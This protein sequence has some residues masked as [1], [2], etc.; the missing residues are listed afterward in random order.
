MPFVYMLFRRIL[1]LLGFYQLTRLAFYFLNYSYFPALGFS[2]WI[3]LLSGSLRFDLSAIMYSNVLYIALFLLPF[4]HR[5]HRSVQ[6]VAKWLFVAV[7][8][9]MLLANLLDSVYYPFTLRRTNASFFREFE[10]DAHLISSLGDF[11]GSHP[12]LILAVPLV[13]FGLWKTYPLIPMPEH[14]RSWASHIMVFPVG[15]LWLGF[16][17]GSFIPSDRPIN[18]SLAADYAPDARSMSL[19]LNTPI[20]VMTTWGNIKVP[21]VNYFPDLAAA[22]NVFDPVQIYPADTLR[23]KNVVIIIVESLSKEFIGALNPGKPSYTPFLDAFIPQALVYP[24][25]FANGRRSIEALPSVVASI[26]SLSEAYVLTPY[27]T[28]RI[29]SLASVL[30]ENGWHTSF[31]HGGHD[32]SMGFSAFMRLAGMQHAYSKTDY[33]NDADYDGT[34]GIY[35]EPYLQY[36]AT[37]LNKHP[38][39]FFSALFTVSSHHP[40]R[41][42]E[43]LEDSIPAGNIPIHRSIRYTDRALQRFF[44]KASAM[45]WYKNTLFVI[46]ADHTS[47]YSDDGDYNNNRGFFAV[48]LLF[49]TPDSSL[50]G[51]QD[52]VAQQ[53]DIY[54]TLCDYLGVKQPIVSWG[55]SLFA[56]REPLVVNYFGGVYQAF[57]DEWLLQMQEDQVIALYAYRTDIRLQHNVKDQHPDEVN[58]I[59]RKLKAYIQSYNSRVRRNDMTVGR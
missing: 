1:L 28:N 22:E 18:I 44:E 20:S 41:I 14:Q 36:W 49:F 33:G 19:V 31:Y 2:E 51:V 32:K 34:W 57:T 6:S 55:R 9:L 10:Q 46:T 50:R 37:S 42:P 45:P 26:P 40:F 11:A 38:Q 48:P 5:N 52:A 16:A 47:A 23:R 35:D 24:N 17:R 3:T 21:E 53:A 58:D 27:V 25:A 29:Q 15:V 8:G 54:P 12:W 56:A 59:A 13:F 39:P 30:A 4:A 7:N 43:Q